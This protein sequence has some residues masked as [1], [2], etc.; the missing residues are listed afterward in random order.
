MLTQ[1]PFTGRY[2]RF[3]NR[4]GKRSPWLGFRL[5]QACKLMLEIVGRFPMNSYA[6]LQLSTT[7][8]L[9][10]ILALGIAL[11]VLHWS[12]SADGDEARYINHAYALANGNIPEYFDGAIAVRIPYL[13][14]LVLW[15]AIFGYTTPAF[16]SSGL[17][18][19]VIGTLLLWIITRKLYCF[20][21]AHVA[22]FLFSTLP[23]HIVLSTHAL[24]DDFALVFALAS[25]ATWIFAMQSTKA[26]QR[27]QFLAVSGLLAGF[28]AGI[29]QPFFLL[30]LILPFG[31]YLSGTRFSRCAI[32]ILTFA[33]S[34]AF[35]LLLES[36][37][38]WA[39][40]G[41][42]AFRFTHD[43]L[44]EGSQSP[45]V[46]LQ[47]RAPMTMLQKILAF[48]GY[49]PSL[50][51]SGRFGI[52]PVLLGLAIADRIVRRDTRAS[53]PLVMLIILAAY[54]FW[55]T[56]SLRIWSL[57]AVNARYLI[58]SVAGGCVLCGAMLTAI[59]GKYRFD[60][61]T[62]IIAFVS[63]LIV[64]IWIVA[65][66]GRPSCVTEFAQHLA[67]IPANER[68][69]LVIPES[70]KRYFLPKDYWKYVEG[71]HV[72]PDERLAQIESMDLSGIRGIAVPNETFYSYAHIGVV[73][74]L[75]RTASWWEKEEV[76]G[77][78]WPR[79]LEITGKPSARVIGHIYYRPNFG[80]QSIYK[81]QVHYACQIT[82][83]LREKAVP[84]GSSGVDGFFGVMNRPPMANGLYVARFLPGQEPAHYA[85]VCRN[86]DSYP[87]VDM[88]AER[89]SATAPSLLWSRL[90]GGDRF[91]HRVVE[92]ADFHERLADGAV[93]Q[94]FVEGS[95]RLPGV[96][97]YSAEAF[98]P[99]QGFGGRHQGRAD[100]APPPFRYDGHLAHADIT[101]VGRR[102]NQAA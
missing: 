54:H 94:P 22:A 74:A 58:P 56:T 28:A 4:I 18:T 25:I 87:S 36:I 8:V 7:G 102:Q 85:L 50:L 39:W 33:L 68:S 31:S 52:V 2:A 12:P 5:H 34:A 71:M 64:N 80:Q 57:P 6:R 49:L 41:N 51:P 59:H 77:K 62:I 27:V 9:V 83:D 29:R 13:G 44:Q 30:G 24:T 101:T 46:F 43:V 76:V 35:Y 37:A 11:R 21:A 86:M 17:F 16:Q 26:L 32:A 72:V 97:H 14:F 100:P 42:P 90:P 69:Q 70:V 95:G 89:P 47:L 40:L 55:G 84:L 99:S 53:I 96:E 38:F 93:S 75:M 78:K 45:M 92:K 23:L 81:Q 65:Y 1:A 48:R 10:A 66:G 60:A 19:Y 15:G 63:T 20:E 88:I 79:Y 61:A 73:D 98:L 3:L 82:P 91:H 67:E